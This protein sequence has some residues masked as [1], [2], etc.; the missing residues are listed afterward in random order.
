MSDRNYVTAPTTCLKCGRPMIWNVMRGHDDK[1]LVVFRTWC[2]PEGGDI[3]TVGHSW[4]RADELWRM[5]GGEALLVSLGKKDREV[6][7]WVAETLAWFEKYGR[8]EMNK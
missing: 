4:A 1:G 8:P 5:Q 2:C 6:A 3:T 7:R